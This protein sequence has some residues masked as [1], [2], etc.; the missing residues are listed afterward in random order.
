MKKFFCLTAIGVLLL[1]TSCTDSSKPA[2]D[3]A[4]S[5]NKENLA[6]NRRVYKAI[7]TG[8]AATLDSLISSD[9]VDHQT[10]T[11]QLM[12]GR[13]SVKNMLKDMHNHMKDANF[14]II[15]DAANGDYIFTLVNVKATMA[16]S[17]WGM[18]PGD[19]MDE[20]GVDVV[21]IKDG[22]MVEHWG[23]VDYSQMMQ[24]INSIPQAK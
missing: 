10:P 15:A 11:G 20:K 21:R 2:T 8:D 7:E 6:K 3:T 12:E 9:A 24:R 18:K 13:D 4:A 22:K 17:S 19:K 1:V 23:F 14:D 16:D 5:Q